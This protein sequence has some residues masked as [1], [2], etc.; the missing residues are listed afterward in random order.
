MRAVVMAVVR[1]LAFVVRSRLTLKVE[2][3][4]LRHQL[5]V[6]QRAGRRP[7]LGARRP[8]PL[9]VA[10]TCLIRVAGDARHRATPHRDRLAA[11]T[12]SRSLDAGEPRVSARPA[13]G[14]QGDPGPD[15][16]NV[17]GQPDLH[18]PRIMGAL[19]KLGI[20]VAKSTVEKYRVRPSTPPSPT[21][22]TFLAT[23]AKDLVSIDFF[24]VA[25]VRFE[26]L[27]VLII[28]AHDR[29]RI[30][31][32]NIT[33]HPTAAWTAQQVVEAFP[34]DTAQLPRRC[35]P[36]TPYSSRRPPRQRP[37]HEFSGGTSARIEGSGSHSPSRCAGFGCRRPRPEHATVTTRVE[38]R[39]RAPH[40]PASL[41]R[42]RFS[43]SGWARQPHIQPPRAIARIMRAQTSIMTAMKM[44]P[45]IGNIH[46]NPAHGAPQEVPQ[47][48]IALPPSVMHL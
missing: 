19:G 44:S 16:Q 25:T 39:R 5:A 7:R 14:R 4:A 13:S 34:W 11:P 38:R 21:W 12:L 40:C 45:T 15:P 29:R 43:T 10:L 46:P 6:Y 28:L 18:A 8:S 30:R 32:F 48:V 17:G 41:R 9:G 3:L 35:A 33:T 37:C 36:T 20:A 23:H 22:R 27:F 47:T 24:T 42:S 26:I 1:S 2:I 31:H